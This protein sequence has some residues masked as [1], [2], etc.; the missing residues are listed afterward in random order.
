[1]V[2]TYAIL[3]EI[4][5]A[6]NQLSDGA[7]LGDNAARV[8]IRSV[9]VELAGAEGFLTT[10]QSEASAVA[11]DANRARGIID[12]TIAEDQQVIDAQRTVAESMDRQVSGLNQ[13]LA[14]IRNEIEG[15]EGFGKGIAIALSFGAYNPIE[16]NRN[17]IRQEIN[18]TNAVANSAR[19]TWSKVQARQAELQACRTTLGRLDDLELRI[20]ALAQ[21]VS[22][23]LRQTT[24]AVKEAELAQAR[25]GGLLGPI[26]A[27]LAAQRIGKVVAWAGNSAHFE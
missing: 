2:G 12:F 1:M 19:L 14:G 6:W 5:T 22:E 7:A 26:F 25:E 20:S 24:D 27:R 4:T 8:L 16:E 3:D 23:G 21:D 13:R 18:A 9:I 10:A 11:S 17:K 15:W